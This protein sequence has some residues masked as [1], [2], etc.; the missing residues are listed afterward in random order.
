[1]V[2]G[3]QPIA[4]DDMRK[5]NAFYRKGCRLGSCCQ[6]DIVGIVDFIAD[7][8]SIHAVLRRKQ[9]PLPFD[10]RDFIAF[11]QLLYAAYQGVHGF[12]LVFTDLLVIIGHAFSVYTETSAFIHLS[13][14]G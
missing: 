6:N 11:E 4:V 9:S 5:I 14:E 1:M 2:E 8:N 12:L 13:V 7:G 3:K 10:E